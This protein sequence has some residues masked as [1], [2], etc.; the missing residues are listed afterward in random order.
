MIRAI[1]VTCA[2]VIAACASAGM[3]SSGAGDAQKEDAPAKFDATKLTSDG[4]PA[5]SSVPHDA[6]IDAFVAKDAPATPDAGGGNVCS[7]NSDCAGSFC[8]YFFVCEHGTGVGSN[9]CFP[10]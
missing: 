6:A 1:V 8:C 9:L 4:S 3:N 5:D 10:N 7:Q 2:I